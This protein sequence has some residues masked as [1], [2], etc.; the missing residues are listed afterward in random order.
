MQWGF[1]EIA[2]PI[3]VSSV[4]QY[5]VQEVTQRMLHDKKRGITWVRISSKQFKNDAVIAF[6][7]SGR[8]LSAMRY[9][10]HS[11]VHFA[12]TIDILEGKP[13]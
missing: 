4:V 2:G 3:A 5:Q 10:T 12:A 1:S 9:R 13:K 7:S 8:V 11:R 6:V